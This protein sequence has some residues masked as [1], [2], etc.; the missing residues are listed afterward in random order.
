MAVWC[1]RQDM[2]LYRAHE[3]TRTCCGIV[4]ECSDCEGLYSV[5]HHLEEKMCPLCG[6]AVVVTADAMQ[7][8][9][10]VDD[11]EDEPDLDVLEPPEGETQDE[12]FMACDLE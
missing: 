3:G 10:D 9:V 1:V 5:E 8:P 12:Y 4:V 6:V 2:T 7:L 11:N